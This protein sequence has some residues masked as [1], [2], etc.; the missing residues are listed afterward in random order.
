[1]QHHPFRRIR[2]AAVRRSLLAI[3]GTAPIFP[4]FAEEKSVSG[5]VFKLEMPLATF[6]EGVATQTVRV[7]PDGK[8]I[9]YMA[10]LPNG[11]EAVFVNDEQ[12]PKY[13]G[14]VNDSLSFSPDSKRVAWGALRDGRKV[15]V[16]DGEEFSAYD[17]SAEGMPVWS[18]D[19]RRFAFFTSMGGR[20]AAVVDGK[21][22]EAW[23]TV[24]KESFVF[25]PDS[26]R[27][28]FI[29]K[30]G[31]YGRVVVDGK[32]GPRHRN[33]AGF[34]FSPDGRHFAYVAISGQSMAVI[35]DGVEMA[36]APA[37]LK[38]TLRFDGPRKL[39]VVRIE[40]NRLIREEIHLIGLLE[41][42]RE[43]EVESASPIP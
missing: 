38:G 31:G 9:A 10:T 8:R 24:I 26:S 40:G 23:D 29:A 36:R 37:F 21:T 19:S 7:S 4:A 1:M 12:S 39:H 33:V 43:S 28:A 42:S 17:G 6:H 34:T 13:G 5:E 35:V 18:S 16:V 30:D 41:T 11:G 15:V 14:I 32:A 27:F 22:G 2:R 25:S 20:I 3:L